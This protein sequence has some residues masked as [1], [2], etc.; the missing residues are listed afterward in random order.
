ML[1]ELGSDFVY[2]WL[3]E[4]FESLLV[5]NV[6]LDDEQNVGLFLG[7]LDAER[8]ATLDGVVSGCALDC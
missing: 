4:F 2:Q 7:D 6:L 3:D 8:V 1:L 5:G